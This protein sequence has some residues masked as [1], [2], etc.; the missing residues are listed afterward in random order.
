M[1]LRNIPKS[2]FAQKL[3]KKDMQRLADEA[4]LA[5][6]LF[7]HKYQVYI[8]AAYL[9]NDEDFARGVIVSGDK[10]RDIQ[11]A[12][13]IEIAYLPIAPDDNAPGLNILELFEEQVPCTFRYESE[14]T[15]VYNILMDHF[16]KMAEYI[17]DNP[18]M[19][20]TKR[21]RIIED[22][23]RFD[24]LA[25]KLH[26]QAHSLLPRHLNANSVEHRLQML[27]RP[28]I[29]NQDTRETEAPQE[30]AVPEYKSFEVGIS[31][32]ILKGSK[33]WRE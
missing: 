33:R 9:Y 27:L 7:R 8:P 1:T 15:K 23:R 20:P 32:S 2:R 29:P 4:P 6:K 5:D 13:E 25:A 12:N 17:Q 24:A 16:K 31:P 22:L 26:P 10:Q 19:N 14:V 30:A 21:E 28:V 3:T 18:L 11:A